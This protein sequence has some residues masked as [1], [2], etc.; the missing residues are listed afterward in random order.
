MSQHQSG[1]AAP[2]PVSKPS[3]L[4][5]IYAQKAK[6]EE[7]NP[8]KYKHRLDCYIDKDNDKRFWAT[9]A[10]GQPEDDIHRKS[11]RRRAG[12]KPSTGTCRALYDFSGE[13]PTDLIFKTG[14]NIILLELVDDQ[15]CKGELK[16][17]QGTFPL[18]FVEITKEIPDPEDEDEKFSVEAFCAF[19]FTGSD[20][21]DLPL[22]AGQMV[23]VT[24]KVDDEWLY[25]ECGNKR[26][27]FPALFVSVGEDEIEMLPLH[28]PASKSLDKQKDKAG[29]P[30]KVTIPV[31]GSKTGTALY[32]FIAENKAELSLRVGDRVVLLGNVDSD[33]TR[34]QCGDNTGLFPS[35]F[36]QFDS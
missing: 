12:Q 1:P 29:E 17:K 9:P 3:A 23:R 2:A 7:E 14:D 21:S 33:W 10:E 30:E 13:T 32:E 24:A 8:D 20:P 36:V 5:R 19:E 6:R 31:A 26:G 18:A 11:D 27:I 28:K 25:G 34:G 16:G 22:K 15:W 4:Q 35:S